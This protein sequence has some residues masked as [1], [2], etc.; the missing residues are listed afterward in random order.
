MEH[1][2]VTGG[3]GY[4][5][6]VLCPALVEAGYEVTVVDQEEPGYGFGGSFVHGDVLDHRVMSLLAGEADVVIPL[7]AVVGAPACNEQPAEARS[8]NLLAIRALCDWCGPEQTIIFPSTA[9]VYGTTPAGSV[10][11]EE[12][13]TNPVSLYGRTK[14]LAERRLRGWDNAVILRLAT[15][16]GPSPSMRW[17]LLLN[18]FVDRA[19]RGEAVEIWEREAKRN[20]IHIKDVVDC[21][22]FA[23][24]NRDRMKG[25]VYNVGNDE[26]NVSKE[27]LF[28]MVQRHIPTAFAEFEFVDTDLAHRDYAV[29]S[30]KLRETGF[31]ATRSLDEAIGEL[32]GEMAHV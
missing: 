11:T 3:A 21:F 32:V 22:L 5:G 8:V 31:V 27:E 1:V 7:A 29:S 14:V 17:A 18:H 15:L 4:L 23:I 12:T 6:S 10:C 19:M 24:E 28:W 9:S 13:P 30:Q 20:Y 16:S 25:Q 26:G 2:L